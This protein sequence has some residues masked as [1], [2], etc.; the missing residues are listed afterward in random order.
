MMKTVYIHISQ[1]IRI[2]TYES[3]MCAWRVLQCFEC[4]SHG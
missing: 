4:L 2:L 3:R 1:H